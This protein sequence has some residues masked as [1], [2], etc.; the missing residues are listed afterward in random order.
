MQLLTTAALLVAIAIGAP[1]ETTGEYE[2]VVVGSGP[3]G[4]TLA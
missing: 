1:V 4:G 2:Y 3:G